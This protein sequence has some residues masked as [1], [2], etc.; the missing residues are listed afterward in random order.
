[1]NNEAL[2]ND[3]TPSYIGVAAITALY[4]AVRFDT[5]RNT[6]DLATAASDAVIGITQ[7]T[8]EN[9][10]EAVAVKRGGYSLATVAAG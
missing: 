4:K 3:S 10:G 5:A 1:M 9:A 2:H 7:G 8:T 6:V